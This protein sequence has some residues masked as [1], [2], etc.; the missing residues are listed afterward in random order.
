MTCKRKIR[1]RHYPRWNVVVTCT[2]YWRPWLEKSLPRN[3][4]RWDNWTEF[5][6]MI[7]QL[8]LQ[9]PSSWAVT[10]L[11]LLPNKAPSDWW[12]IQGA[13]R[14]SQSCC[15]GK[16]R[17]CHWSRGKCHKASIYRE[18]LQCV[19]DSKSYWLTRFVLILFHRIPNTKY[20]SLFED[21]RIPHLAL[22][23]L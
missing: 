9:N 23:K 12:S 2:E 20:Y 11:R 3:F 8:N 15:Y 19:I 13:I 7:H 1:I 21:L 4:E 22:D 16:T 6:R 14:S 5:S 18:W 17:S 10:I